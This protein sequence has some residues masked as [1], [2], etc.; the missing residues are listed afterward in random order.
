VINP[1]KEQYRFIDLLMPENGAVVRLL[2][3]EPGRATC[4]AS[5]GRLRPTATRTPPRCP[6]A[7]PAPGRRPG[8]PEPYTSLG[9]RDWLSAALE[10]TWHR[11]S[12]G[13]QRER[14]R[15]DFDRDRGLACPHRAQTA[16]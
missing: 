4:S 7:S 11:S 1:I 3:L 15:V 10:T 13:R 16:T 9:A 5:R 12:E 2:A 8:A 6:R 14:P